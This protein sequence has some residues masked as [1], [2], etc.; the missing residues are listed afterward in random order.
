VNN[1]FS[2]LSL[3]IESRNDNECI[4]SLIYMGNSLGISKEGA[5][6]VFSEIAFAN[7]SGFDQ[8][9]QSQFS[10]QPRSQF[11]LVGPIQFGF[12]LTITISLRWVLP[13]GRRWF[14]KIMAVRICLM[15]CRCQNTLI[16]LDSSIGSVLE[17]LVLKTAAECISQR[18]NWTS[19]ARVMIIFW[20]PLLMCPQWCGADFP[21]SCIFFSY[22]SA[23]KP[24]YRNPRERVGSFL[25][26]MNLEPLLGTVTCPNPK[27]M[28]F[29]E[30]SLLGFSGWVSE[31]SLLQFL[32][33][34]RYKRQF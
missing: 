19:G 25:E 26:N 4:R 17:R 7:Q 21:K 24:N 13:C 14:W 32:S 12:C 3:Q 16:W 31:K 9:K 11:S 33:F 2:Q 10:P 18:L 28:I 5:L 29:G 6:W 34:L 27:I 15:S 23:A 22:N 20:C 30:Y 1:F 8:K